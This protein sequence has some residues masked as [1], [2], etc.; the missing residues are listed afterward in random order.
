[1]QGCRD[2]K[3]DAS[4]LTDI[5]YAWPMMITGWCCKIAIGRCDTDSVKTK[6]KLDGA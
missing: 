1:M 4:Y 6:L 5:L 2:Q 3:R